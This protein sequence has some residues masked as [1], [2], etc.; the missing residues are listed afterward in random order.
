M[1]CLSF[2]PCLVSVHV[3]HLQ[4]ESCSGL[5]WLLVILTP[6]HRTWGSLEVV[7]GSVWQGIVSQCSKFGFLPITVFLSASLSWWFLSWAWEKLEQGVGC[8]HPSIPVVGGT[9][10]ACEGEVLSHNQ[11]LL[12]EAFHCLYFMD[13]FS[14]FITNKHV[15]SHGIF[16]A[17]VK[18][19]YLL[20][21]PPFNAQI[22]V[23]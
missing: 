2:Y 20:I 1:S 18:L 4:S 23:Q 11:A 14:Y 10:C 19:P 3:K 15:N 17:V 8:T 13:L 5:C 7:L 16:Y 22:F 6:G 21:F 12:A 9:L